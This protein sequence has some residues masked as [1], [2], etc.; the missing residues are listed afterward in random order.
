M[1]ADRPIFN[2]EFLPCSTSARE[3]ALRPRGGLFLCASGLVAQ[4]YTEP[5]GRISNASRV[6]H[7]LGPE[8]RI[9]SR[10]ERADEQT[11]FFG[12]AESIQVGFRQS[13]A[14]ILH[15]LRRLSQNRIRNLAEP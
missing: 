12:N 9:E 10:T 8:I 7:F 5:V 3:P 6:A 15:E 14:V 11:A 1:S 2:V 13:L 4:T